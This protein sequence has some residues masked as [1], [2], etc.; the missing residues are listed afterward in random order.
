MT[1]E[2]NK[3]E[4]NLIENAIDSLERSMDLLVW[5]DEQDEA[6]KLKQAI[7]SVA[8]GVELLLKEQLRHVH[9]ALVW[10]NVDKYPSLSA[11]TVGV[12]AAI[13]RL[14]NIG[15]IAFNDRDLKLIKSL[16]DKR[17]AIEHFSWSI[18]S[19]EANSI[20][21]EALGFAVFFSKNYLG[22]DFFGYHKKDDDT[23]SK[24]MLK[25]PEFKLAYLARE[26]QVAESKN[27]SSKK[28]EFCNGFGQ[29]LATGLCALC[30]HLTWLPKESGGDFDDDIPL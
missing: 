19:R 23:F 4:F 8:H 11:R 9:P 18:S 12:D 26:T 28:C 16:R 22:Y 13:N 7:L 20:V 3:I 10:E 21:G 27:E 2:D 14:I 25:N 24:L 5:H 17:N 15:G 1:V 30:G 29:N 6:R